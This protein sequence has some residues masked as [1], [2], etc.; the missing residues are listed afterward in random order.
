MAA[1]N[2]QSL[3]SS[4]SPSSCLTSALLPMASA[5]NLVAPWQN[6]SPLPWS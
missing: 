5:F 1:E 6:S 4:E 3:T 2:P